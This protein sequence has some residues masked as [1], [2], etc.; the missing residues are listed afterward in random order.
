MSKH[1]RSFLRSTVVSPEFA[2]VIIAIGVGFIEPAWLTKMVTNIDS[3]TDYF[4]TVL[5]APVGIL[6]W[7]LTLIRD[8]KFPSKDDASILQKAPIYPELKT[9]CG[10]ALA[11]SLFFVA[12]GALATLQLLPI[13][14]VLTTF[15]LIVSVVGSAVVGLTCWQASIAVNEIIATHN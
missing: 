6:G 7:T 13:T 1:V 2:I 14:P 11:Y 5:L 3:K 10:V 12:V 9:V 15:T 4:E 8:I